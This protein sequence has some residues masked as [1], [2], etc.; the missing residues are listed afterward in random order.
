MLVT[1][2]G[3]LSPTEFKAEETKAKIQAWLFDHASNPPKLLKRVADGELAHRNA[4][5]RELRGLGVDENIAD[6]V[7]RF[8]CMKVVRRFGAPDTRAAFLLDNLEPPPPPPTE[9]EIA[10]SWQIES[11]SSPEANDLF[12]GPGRHPQDVLDRLAEDPSAED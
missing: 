2:A 8:L 6:A 11:H 9:E 5:L 1:T 3:T 7:F 4:F 10:R 12:Y